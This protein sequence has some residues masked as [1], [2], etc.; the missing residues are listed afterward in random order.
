VGHFGRVWVRGWVHNGEFDKRG[1][2]SAQLSKN[3][4]FRSKDGYKRGDY[5]LNTLSKSVIADIPFSLFP[6][7]T[8]Q[9][10]DGFVDKSAKHFH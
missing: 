7:R 10:V 4:N 8:F 1:V 3:V 2:E 5:V 9:P 6:L